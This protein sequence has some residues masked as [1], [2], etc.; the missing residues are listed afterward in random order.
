MTK[1][2]G[3]ND[4]TRIK[5]PKQLIAWERTSIDDDKN[6]EIQNNDSLNESLHGNENRN[7]SII[8]R[9]YCNFQRTS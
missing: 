9:E 6:Y 8:N 5:A 1:I 2:N 4:T 7:I 3:S